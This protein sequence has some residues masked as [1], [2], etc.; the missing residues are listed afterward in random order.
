MPLHF[1][2][3]KFCFAVGIKSQGRDKL[4]LGEEVRCREKSSKELFPTESG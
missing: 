2:V 1:S 3:S 4:C